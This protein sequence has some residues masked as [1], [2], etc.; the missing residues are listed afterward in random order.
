MAAYASYRSS[1]TRRP[2]KWSRVV[3]SNVAMA[4]AERSRTWSTYRAMSSRPDPSSRISMR[5]SSW[6]TSAAG[7]S[8]PPAI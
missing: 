4:P 3:P 2:A 6:A 7:S 8:S 1:T 5:S